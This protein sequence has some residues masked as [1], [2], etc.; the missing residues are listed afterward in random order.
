MVIGI[1]PP[2]RAELAARVCPRCGGILDA[3]RAHP[4]T[5]ARSR[6]CAGCNAWHPCTAERP[7]GDGGNEAPGRAVALVG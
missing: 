5:V 3:P 6:K 4:R 2:R 1:T 7:L